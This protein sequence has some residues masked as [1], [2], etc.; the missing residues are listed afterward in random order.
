MSPASTWAAAAGSHQRGRSSPECIVCSST[1]PSRPDTCRARRGHR[2]R[3]EA[4]VRGC[5]GCTRADACCPSCKSGH[6]DRRCTAPRSR[7]RSHSNTPLPGRPAT[8]SPPRCSTSRPRT[9]G[10]SSRWRLAAVF[11]PRTARTCLVPSS[12]HSCRGCSARAV[13]RH[14]HTSSPPDTRSTQGGHRL[15]S[16]CHTCP[17]RTWAAARGCCLRGRSDRGRIQRTR[18]HWSD[19]DTS[20]EGSGSTLGCAR[21]VHSFPARTR[22]AR[23]RLHLKNAREGTRC[24]RRRS[25]GRGDC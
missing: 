14:P 13:V 21:A 7:G 17:V 23:G 22:W 19:P 2:A 11:P 15:H 25:A 10:N 8:R 16:C 1:A 9:A 5:R 6:A 12:P 20:R 3:C 24:T 18:W 4:R